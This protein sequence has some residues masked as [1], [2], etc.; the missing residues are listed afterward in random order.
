MK[1]TISYTYVFG[2]SI[3]RIK[4]RRKARTILDVTNLH[5]CIFFSDQPRD[6]IFFFKKFK[7]IIG[8][9]SVG[10]RDLK[11][12]GREETRGER[13]EDG[14]GGGAPASERRVKVG[15]VTAWEG[16]GEWAERIIGLG[17]AAN[18]F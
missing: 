2:D 9:Y 16:D 7:I 10:G 6:L 18:I 14:G 13:E 15:R 17:W 12:S 3:I 1:F 11:A 4:E 8:S 5:L